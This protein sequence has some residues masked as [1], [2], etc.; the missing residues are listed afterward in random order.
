MWYSSRSLFPFIERD[1][2]PTRVCSKQYALSQ[3]ANYTTP[4]PFL[5]SLTAL[6]A[7][8]ALLVVHWG[9]SGAALLSLPTREY[10]QSSGWVNEAE[11]SPAHPTLRTAPGQD[12]AYV[13]GSVRSGSGFWAAGPRSD[14]GASSS[15]FTAFSSTQDSS[16]REHE[17][18]TD[19]ADGA[20]SQGTE[21]ARARRRAEDGDVLD[22]VGAQDAFVAGMIY[23]LSRRVL[24]G[25]PYTPSARG[26]AVEPDRGKWKLEDCLR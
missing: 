24:P 5:L 10:F 26:V 15:R 13:V 22:D 25:A 19:D 1:T 2:V 14:G 6:A 3:S 11:V 7:P 23:A 9:A 12:D 21:T 8:H 16:G 17:H 18:D 20:D 4:R